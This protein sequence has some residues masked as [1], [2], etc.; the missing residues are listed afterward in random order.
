MVKELILD[1]GAWSVAHGTS[2]LTL[3]Q[4]IAYLK[5]HAHQ[6][7][8][9]FNFD[10]DFSDKGFQ[11]NIIAQTEMENAGLHPVPVVH[12][13]YDGEIDYLFKGGSYIHAAL[14]SSQTSRF[15][16]LDYG[17]NTIKDINPA[18]TVH[19]FGGA[20]FEWLVNTTVDSCDT[21]SWAK[22][23]AYGGIR[24]WNP[25]KDGLDKTDLVYIGDRL[26]P[27]SNDCY[28]YV[29]YPWRNDLDAFL[30]NTFKW[31]NPLQELTGYSE[32][33][34]KQLI[35]LHYYVELENRVIAERRALLP[36]SG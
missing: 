5:M 8:A 25:R 27:A 36:T 24:Y 31:S 2:D 21:S 4:Y 16:D 26:E 17:C 19:W 1:S 32:A 12:N 7:D 6:F 23:G 14:G 35:N 18:I 34:N 33:L 3:T 15:E 30:K 28:R 11:N 13:L 20:R 22:S 10:T 9:Y 29:A